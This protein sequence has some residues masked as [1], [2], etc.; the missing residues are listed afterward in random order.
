MLRKAFACTALVAAAMALGTVP[1][2]AH[3]GN[4]NDDDHGS[5][6]AVEWNKGK[7]AALESAGGSKIAAGGF[8]QGGAIG[9]EW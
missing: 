4:D 6:H 3:G 9:A 1:A 7:F 2:A 8:N 5:F